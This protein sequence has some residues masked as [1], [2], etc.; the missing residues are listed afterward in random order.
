M[1]VLCK[2]SGNRLGGTVVQQEFGMN[3]TCILL[4][5]SEDVRG[6]VSISEAK[7]WRGGGD[8]E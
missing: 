4:T 6:R 3:L 5:L 7:G 2:Q 8:F 1:K